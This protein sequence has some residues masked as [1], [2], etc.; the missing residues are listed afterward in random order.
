MAIY[1]AM[2][3]AISSYGIITWDNDNLQLLFLQMTWSIAF[4]LGGQSAANVGWIRQKYATATFV[5][6]IMCFI[7]SFIYLIH[8][9]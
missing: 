5:G 1:S 8:T 7:L 9:L 3:I 6:G 4:I 2:Y